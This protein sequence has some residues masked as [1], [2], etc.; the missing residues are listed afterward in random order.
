M[1]VKVTWLTEIHK[2]L[3]NQLKLLQGHKSEKNSEFVA[4]NISIFFL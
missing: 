4:S 1:E 3:A 2:V